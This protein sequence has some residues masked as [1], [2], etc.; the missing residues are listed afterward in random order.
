LNQIASPRDLIKAAHAYIA[1]FASENDS[2]AYIK[3]MGRRTDWG[4]NV[5]MVLD[6]NGD[7]FAAFFQKLFT[8]MFE[9]QT[10]PIA[11]VG[12]APQGH[13]PRHADNPS[14]IFAAE[15]GHV[16]FNRT[17]NNSWKGA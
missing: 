7:K 17:A 14:S 9:G 5:V 16:T 13:S 11:W 2:N 8:E 1:V 10:M 4:A 3:R 15:A 6:R 12:L